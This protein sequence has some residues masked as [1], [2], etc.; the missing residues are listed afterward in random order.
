MIVTA[1]IGGLQIFDEPRLYGDDQDL[2]GPNGQW[3]TLTLYLYKLGWN[4]LDFG[5]ASAVAWLLFTLIAVVALIN[6]FV[7]TRIASNGR[8][9][10][11]K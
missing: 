3:L 4:D 7:T 8:R 11:Q 9:K 2:G 1:T 10:G 5:R 6:L